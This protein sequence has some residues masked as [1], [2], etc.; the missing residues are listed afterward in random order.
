M[1]HARITTYGTTR[2]YTDGKTLP[3]GMSIPGFPGEL[4]ERVI[5]HRS[6]IACCQ[7]APASEDLRQT[8]HLDTPEGCLDIGQAIIVSEHRIVFEDE[9]AGTV[10]YGVWHR[11]PMLT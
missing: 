7:L 3:I 5:I 1:L 9:L 11:H 10:P 6:H 8:L 2:T 4:Q